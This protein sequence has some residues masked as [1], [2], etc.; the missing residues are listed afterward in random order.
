M[1]HAKLG[2]CYYPEQWPPDL[3]PDDARR[4]ADLGLSIVRIGEFAWSRLEPTD[5]NIQFDW[6]ARSIDILADAGLDVVLGTPTATPPKWL[7]DKMPDMAQIAAD[8]RRRKF[9]SRRHY[10]FSHQG[11]REECRRMVTLLGQKF[12]PHPA[13][14][15]WQIDNEFACHDTTHS[16]SDAALSGF[17]VWLNKKYQSI[18]N[19]NR[20]WGNVF[21]S[22]EYADFQEIELP[23]Q[24]VTTANPAHWMDFYRYSSAQVCAFNRL[25]VD[26]IRKYA[27]GRDIV[28]NFMGRTLDF[29]H[30]DL[31][32]DLD[33][34]SWDSYPLGFLGDRMDV[35]DTHKAEFLRSGDPD[36]QAFHHDLYRSTSAGRW[37]V[38][39]QQPGPVN[40]AADNPAPDKGMVRLWAWEA[41]AHGA[42]VVSFFRW[43]QVPYGQEQYHA[44]LLRPDGVAAPGFFEA[45]QVAR[46]IADLALDLTTTETADVALVFDYPSA[47]A[48]SIHPQGA[49]FD[50]FNLLF[51]L[52]QA[53]R[54]SG[55][56]VDFVSSQSTQRLSQKILLV[57]G[58]FSW[59]E[60]LRDQ[61]AEFSGPVLIGPRTGSKT[62][63]Y[64]IPD[65]LPPD[66]EAL[67]PGLKVSHV[68]SL[69]AAVSMQ[70]D[71]GGGI[72]YWREFVD[73]DASRQTP[74]EQVAGVPVLLKQKNLYYLSAWPDET[75]ALRLVKRLAVDAGFP[76]LSLPD[77]LRI[78]SRGSYTFIFNYGT[79]VIDLK[80][81]FAD[82]KPLFGP[83]ELIRG[84]VSILGSAAT[85][86]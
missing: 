28:H 50:Y 13:V 55:L 76:P 11:Y 86:K 52:Y 62:D 54:K 22:M 3:W 60:T 5:G 59:P 73:Y 79:S 49:A 72:K 61:I 67:F 43:R 34:S 74:L 83:A 12:G 80:Q 24:T 57:A 19:L 1:T 18:G 27:P 9:G 68:E 75:L 35:D 63:G 20:Q 70:A 31:G 48:W 78:R 36:F 33:V 39:E 8:G 30:Y 45:Q 17:R 85:I 77:G 10:C 14:T 23:N 40:W 2:V 65:G 51:G 32:R 37:W 53:L 71:R 81:I 6:L 41:I 56:S 26:I 4:M 21:W 69:P 44:G 47:W 29:D 15:A 46:E 66:M 42:E 7:F 64:S 58:L 25:Q 16:F 84:T 82:P 38:M